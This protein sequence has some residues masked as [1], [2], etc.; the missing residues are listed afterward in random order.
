M[1]DDAGGEGSKS[2]AVPILAVIVAAVLAVILI[3]RTLIPGSK[4]NEGTPTRSIVQ[5][6]RPQPG[7]PDLS[8]TIDRLCPSVGEVVPHGTD[9]ASV[10][11]TDSTAIPA[12]VVSA[13]GWL[14]TSA[15]SL[16]Q[17][18]LD[19]V[20]GDGSRANLS[21]VRTDPVS[22][23]SIIKSDRAGTF[24]LAFG[25][26]ALPRVGQFGFLLETP[27][28]K[29]CSARA[30]MVESDFLADGGKTESYVRIETDPSNWTDGDPFLGAD[31]R[32]VGVSIATPVGGLIPA[33]IASVIVDEL[34][35]SELS[36]STSFGFRVIDYS[37]GI[38][39]RL[40]NLR[41]G[42]GVALVQAKSTA[43]KAGLQAGDIITAVND[44]PVS[45]ASELN[46]AMDAQPRSATLSVQRG[47]E[48]L[49]MKVGRTP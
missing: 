20:F 18:Q 1:S 40:G 31:G 14:V 4:Q 19:V 34:I 39:A 28:G 22:G 11:N 3:G 29:G 9:L 32:L 21:E 26:Q 5:I 24:P 38:A 33:P 25:D 7:L 12:F 17:G 8:D 41:T 44:V 6:V 46:R 23:L 10:G 30:A 35:R 36:P 15:G 47:S 43:A 16:P 48:Q 27:I 37:A 2:R 13:D 45:S 42:A 49:T